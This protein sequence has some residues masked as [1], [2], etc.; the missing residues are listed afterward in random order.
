MTRLVIVNEFSES[1]EVAIT[2]DTVIG[3]VGGSNATA[4][5]KQLPTGGTVPAV[6][7]PT[8]VSSFREAQDTFGWLT[9]PS[10]TGYTGTFAALASEAGSNATLHPVNSIPRALHRIFQNVTDHVVVSR[11]DDSEVTDAATRAGLVNAALTALRD[12]N[13]TGFKPTIIVVPFETVTGGGLSRTDTT[14]QNTVYT[15][16][17]SICADL[18][19]MGIVA[20]PYVPATWQASAVAWASNVNSS[21]SRLYSVFPPENGAGLSIPSAETQRFDIAPAVAGALARHDVEQGIHSN[22]RGLNI[23]GISDLVEIVPFNPFSATASES[24]LRANNISVVVVRD[25]FKLYGTELSVPTDSTR[26]DRFVQ[27][28]RVKEDIIDHLEQIGEQA[29]ERNIGSDTFEFVSGRVNAYLR[30][31]EA[32]GALTNGIC[33]PDPMFNTEA[34]LASGQIHFI[35]TYNSVNPVEQITFNVGITGVTGA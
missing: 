16:L 15:H 25:G 3:L 5:N 30:R 35:V 7:T 19:A 2:S 27:V 9:E 31:R 26:R 6:N 13:R 29:V 8:V 34:E 10:G 32:E 11:F 4:G 33:Y 17:N 14:A 22:P 23:R 20:A 12:N 21:T 18:D 28:Y 24:V 1:P